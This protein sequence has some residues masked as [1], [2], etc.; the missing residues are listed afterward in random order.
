MSQSL[1][2][3]LPCVAVA[4]FVI[5]A[6]AMLAVGGGTRTAGW[7]V[8][9]MFALLFFVWSVHTVI[10]EGPFG[11]WTEHSRNAWSNQIW[12]DLLLAIGAAF[13]LLLPRARAAGMRPLPWLIFI[14]CSGSVGLFAM[15]SRCLFL[16]T[17][18]TQI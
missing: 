17:R 11:F 8:A 6:F 9:A 1:Y 18:K 5:S 3:I 4:V 13:F 12:F 15:I 2:A 16:E 10:S 14:L 7:K